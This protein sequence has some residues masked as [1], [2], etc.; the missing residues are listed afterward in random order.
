MC[1]VRIYQDLRVWG[2]QVLKCALANST[3]LIHLKQNQYFHHKFEGNLKRDY[4][5]DEKST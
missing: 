1:A 4:Q 3:V 5:F 2:L